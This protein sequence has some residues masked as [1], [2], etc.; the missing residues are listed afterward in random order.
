MRSALA[1]SVAAVAQAASLSIETVHDGAAPVLTSV[2]AEVIPDAYIV[3]FKDH[4][5]AAAAEHHQNWIHTVHTQGEEQRL[6]LRKRSTASLSAEIFSGLKHSF[7]IGDDFK[8]Y[9]GHFHE[10]VIEQ[11]RNHPDVSLHISQARSRSLRGH[12]ASG[13]TQSLLLC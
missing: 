11:L 9:A 3:K 7:S 6:E 2:G 10:S 5:D 13:C 12:F 1:L 4:V 8:G